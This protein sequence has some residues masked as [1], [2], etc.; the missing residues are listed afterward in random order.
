M[1]TPSGNN[2]LEMRSLPLLV[3]DIDGVLNPYAAETCPDGF[4]EVALFPDGEPVR[5]CALHAEWLHELSS[6]FDLVWGSS[7]SEAD[8]RL[9]LSVLDLPVF[10]GAVTL[11]AGR[12]DPR[13]KV[14]AVAALA[15][16]RPAAWI[17][18]LLTAEAWEWARR[19]PVPTLLVPIDPSVGLTREVVDALI[20]WAMS[21]R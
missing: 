19:R 18:D 17:D 4:V 6:Y 20:Q 13:Q 10:Q 14:P 21:L 9:L 12:F 7:W 15:G 8:R 1:G 2:E 11:P 5:V 3:V 16:G